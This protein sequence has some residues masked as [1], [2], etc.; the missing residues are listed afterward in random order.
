[1]PR[2]VKWRRVG[3]LPEER[4]FTP[5]G[6]A[7]CA[8]EEVVLKVEELEAMRLKDIEDLNQEQCAEKMN[9]SRQTFQLIIDRARSKTARALVEGKAIRIRGGNYTVNIC[10]YSCAECGN[11]F[12]EPFEKEKILCPRCTS[13]DVRCMGESGFC[14]KRCG[15][16]SC[17]R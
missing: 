14:K 1:M 2:P 10:R 7:K 9:I 11:E 15:K 12:N 4:Y 8:L 13:E 16:G 17:C 6:K 3:L 5:E